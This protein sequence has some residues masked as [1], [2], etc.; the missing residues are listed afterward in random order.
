MLSYLQGLQGNQTH[1]HHL[2]IWP[3]FLGF[4][5][6]KADLLFF[7]LT[8]LISTERSYFTDRHYVCLIA[9]TRN[10]QVVFWL[11]GSLTVFIHLPGFISCIVAEHCKDLTQTQTHLH[12]KG[13]Q[14]KQVNRHQERF[15]NPH[16]RVQPGPSKALHHPV[17]YSIHQKVCQGQAEALTCSAYRQFIWP[18]PGFLFWWVRCLSQGCNSLVVKLQQTPSLRKCVFSS[19]NAVW[20]VG[21]KHQAAYPLT[22]ASGYGNSS[23]LAVLSLPSA[24]LGMWDLCPH[25]LVVA[26]KE[27]LDI[28]GWKLLQPWQIPLL[29]S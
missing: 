3:P 16:L 19:L 5:L 29:F 7:F 25:C 21:N 13:L 15:L 24:A 18:L 12:V 27:L 11:H 6:K 1:L 22:G 26:F 28:L 2:R 4:F 9:A 20:A 8:Y 10:L 23:E 14:W 17:G